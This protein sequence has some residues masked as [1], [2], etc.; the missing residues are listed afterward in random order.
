MGKKF[1]L[2]FIIL[3]VAVLAFSLSGCSDFKE[4]IKEML[5]KPIEFECGEFAPST[6]DLSLTVKAYELPLLDGFENLKA[7]DF[8]N[9][10]C[11]EEIA[12]W[13][14]AHPQ[15][16][17]RCAVALPN[18]DTVQLMI[19]SLDLSGLS[20]QQA[21][22]MAEALKLLPKLSRVELGKSSGTENDLLFDDLALL[23]ASNPTVS[24]ICDDYR[25]VALGQT[26]S[27][28]DTQIDL[29][30]IAPED[31][32]TA[33]NLVSMMPKLEYI[34]LGKEGG[35]LR[36][37]DIL[38]FQRVFPE[39]EQH[40]EFSLYGQT[41]NIDVETMDFSFQPIT[42]NGESLRKVLPYLMRLNYVDMDSCGIS[43]ERMAAMQAEFPN[44][45]LVWRVFFGY[46]YTLRTDEERLL[47]SKVS[48]GGN[49]NQNDL[50]D[51][52]YCTDLKYLDLGHNINITDLSFLSSLT[53]LEVVI[54]AMN[55]FTDISPLANSHNIEYLEL[56]TSK[57]ESVEP[58]RNMTKLRHLNIGCTNV[59]DISPLYGLELERLWIGCITPVPAEQVEE[60]QALHPDCQI[61]TGVVDPSDGLWRYARTNTWPWPHHERYALLREQMGHSTLDYNFTWKDEK[62]MEHFG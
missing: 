19:D 48:Q 53:K 7:V 5:A 31:V 27:L 6:E 3:A 60:M 23:R 9:S 24:F 10:T 56:Y 57:L 50:A 54:L 49:L 33:M 26:V 55:N 36:W 62:Y 46:A 13:A 58:L 42:D 8:N 20:H 47:A 15:V 40:Y 61:D 29:S 52:K 35:S 2:T 43:N 18:G 39:I 12:A 28:N 1:R 34:E 51:L 14:E 38:Q 45:K 30:A 11:Y 37:E 17:V 44:V 4:D 22:P 25:F 21:G 59:S 32:P 41:F 16:D